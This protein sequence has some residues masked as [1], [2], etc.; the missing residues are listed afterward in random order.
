MCVEQ[1]Q[2]FIEGYLSEYNFDQDLC[3][4]HNDLL[5]GNIL[6]NSVDKKYNFI[7]FEYSGFGYFQMEI[8]NILIESSYD[9][10]IKNEKGY[11]QD[12]SC[13]PDLEHIRKLLKYY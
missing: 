3:L 8:Y 11:E 1:I 6:F 7:D 12:L 9:Y 2:Q 4:I 5:N 10:D 13:L